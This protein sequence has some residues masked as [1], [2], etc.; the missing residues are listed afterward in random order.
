MNKPPLQFRL[1]S[2]LYLIL[3]AGILLGWYTDRKQLQRELE[4]TRASLQDVRN[5][6]AAEKESLRVM[7][8]RY[9]TV[10]SQLQKFQKEEKASEEVRREQGRMQRERESRLLEDR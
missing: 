5:T 2:M 9:M 6:L 7:F 10:E 8:R 1:A 4:Q 3:V